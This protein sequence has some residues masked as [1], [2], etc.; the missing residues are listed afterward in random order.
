M[1]KCQKDNNYYQGWPQPQLPFRFRSVP[2]NIPHHIPARNLRTLK[3][4]T[5]RYITLQ[6]LLYSSTA[7]IVFINPFLLSLLYSQRTFY[8]RAPQHTYMLACY[9]YKCSR[10][11]CSCWTT[12]CMHQVVYEVVQFCSGI[13]LPAMD[14]YI[15]QLSSLYCSPFPSDKL[16][17]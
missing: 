6:L 16:Y 13:Y 12:R 2:E 17:S 14:A 15:S 8:Y 9:S 11:Y 5:L 4:P 7:Y 3:K 10:A 1:Q